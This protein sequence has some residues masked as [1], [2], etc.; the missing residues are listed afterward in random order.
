MREALGLDVVA[1]AIQLGLLCW[2]GLAGGMSAASACA[3]IGVACGLSSIV[4][5]YVSRAEF[6]I[7]KAQVLTEARRSWALGKWLLA[8]QATVS[9]QCYI[10]YWLLTLLMGS[11]S[12]GVYAACMSIACLA[13][14][15]MTG[16][17]NA[18]APRAVVALNEGGRARLRR[19]AVR[20][21]MLLGATMSLFCLVLIFF[22]EGVMSL[23]YHG[24]E[25]AGQGKIISMQGLG[26]LASAIGFPASFGLTILERPQAV[27]WAGSFGV[28]LTVM[29]GLGLMTQWGLLGAAC[30]FLAGSVAGAVGLWV[31]FLASVRQQPSDIDAKIAAFVVQPEARQV[32]RRPNEKAASSEASRSRRHR[33]FGSS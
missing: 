8:G 22:A 31:A 11:P 10:M 21:A 26:L 5:L 13:N 12:T 18:L 23:L 4:W 14:P 16:L 3:A 17:N 6:A 29:I 30:G 7:R 25:F 27:F 32:D 9:L 1:A 28:L 24:P 19:E 2:W 15:V 20:D 33:V